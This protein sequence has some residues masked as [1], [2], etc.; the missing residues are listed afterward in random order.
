MP[1]YVSALFCAGAM[2]VG[3]AALA[4]DA[5]H[6]FYVVKDGNDMWFL[7]EVAG[8]KAEAER[9]GAG[10]TTQNVELNANLAITG[11]DNAIAG[12]A[13]GIVIVVPEQQIGPAV[14]KK[15][16]DAGIPIIAVDDGIVDEAGNPAPFVGFSSVD[17]GKQVGNAIADIYEELGWTTPP[18]PETAIITA[19][20][21]TVSVCVDRTDNAI[22]VL[23]DRLGMTEEQVIHLAVPGSQDNAM[24]TAA[25]A[26]VAYPSVNKWL[27]AGCNDNGVLGVVRA[28]EQ[29]GYTADDMIGVGVNGQIA[30]EEF[31]KPE[32]TGFKASIYVDSA[33]HGATAIR[34]LHDHVTK[35][36]AIPERTIIAGTLITKDDNEAS[37]GKL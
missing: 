24:T 3:S 9:L 7:N 23:K 26:V 15:A 2:L 11:V 13:D 31:K 22:G 4:Q 20:A 27:I 37:C 8:A 21:Q 34:E 19:E 32:A 33:I 18:G 1:R 16:A 6:F 28:L 29:A 35:G 5:P 25:Q 30:C 10:F 12:G 14:M 36:E 17:A